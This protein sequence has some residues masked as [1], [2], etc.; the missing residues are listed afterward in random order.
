MHVSSTRKGLIDNERIKCQLLFRR[1]II[2]VGMC[3][4]I[5]AIVN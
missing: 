1:Y 2:L 5:V 4:K 3:V